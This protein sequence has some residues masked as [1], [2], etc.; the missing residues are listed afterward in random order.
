[1]GL[2]GVTVS[3]EYGGVEL[4]YFQHTLAMEAISDASG[5]VAL[6]YGG[7]WSLRPFIPLAFSLL[8]TLLRILLPQLI[9]IILQ[10]TRTSV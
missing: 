6:S 4:G 9:L 5:S 3:S 2:L 10:L 8:K 7:A 1:M